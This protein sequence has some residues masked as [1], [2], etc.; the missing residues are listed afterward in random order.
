M[1]PLADGVM[2]VL[3]IGGVLLLAPL[4]GGGSPSLVLAAFACSVM[5]FYA[6]MNQGPWLGGLLGL[7]A[8]A[9]L[10]L[11]ESGGFGKPD[12]LMLAVCAGLAGSGCFF[13]KVL[14]KSRLAAEERERAAT[15]LRRE[16]YRLKKER[17][18]AARPRT[19]TREAPAAKADG[20]ASGPGSELLRAAVNRIAASLLEPRVIE[21]TL[22]GARELLEVDRAVFHLHDRG[23]NRF[24]PGR[25]FADELSEVE[26]G[27]NLPLLQLAH[28]RR[29]LLAR[30]SG[31]PE[32]DQA[33]GA[34]DPDLCL[35]GP[36]FDRAILT[37]VLLTSRPVTERWDCPDLLN[38]LAAA[39]GLALS[40]ARLAVRCEEQ[41]RHDPLT[42]LI[43]LD[44]I[45][46]VL[47]ESLARG[48]AAVLLVAANGVRKVN[49]SYGRRAGDRVVSS[50]A[51]LV[52]MEVGVDGKVGRYG[53][54]TLLVVL[55][56]HR[57]EAANELAL[58]LKRRVPMSICA[59]PEGLAEPLSIS[60]GVAAASA[61]S[62]DML[63][64][65][66]EQA[67][68]AEQVACRAEEQHA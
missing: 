59:G 37:G 61:G 40:G 32:V 6:A 9:G 38:I 53:G 39:C 4:A 29:E 65:C 21:S 12:L 36:V 66:A 35:V 57:I 41:S 30:G 56:G 55:P 33:F 3:A 51:R 63:T 16:L 17:Q 42:G 48:P 45:R 25:Q 44:T 49:G 5:V 52:S 68:A 54:A 58:L 47:E 31:D 7:T 50:L 15:E 60:I 1:R 14:E 34:A 10:V 43:D 8:G 28:K 67:L 62:V 46:S 64:N 2:G 22:T 19:A 18:D 13:G 24:L 23:A 27:V 20:T 11:T 26:V